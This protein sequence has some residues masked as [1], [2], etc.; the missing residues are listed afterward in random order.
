MSDT[1]SREKRKQNFVDA[2]VQGA[3]L[4]RICAHW[5]IFFTVAA[6][7]VVLIKTLLG[8]PAQSFSQRFQTEIGEF[9][10]IGLV[11]L[12]LFP[13]FMLDTIRFSNRFVGP[14]ARVRRHLRQL[15]EGDTQR[16]SF[17]END[18]WGELANDF[19]CAADLVDRQNSEL[20]KLITAKTAAS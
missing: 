11:M 10:L 17:R 7:A 16:C 20:A 9:A 2:H 19:N 1:N 15:G 12:T 5:I 18:F 4:R 6:V 3:L 14:I 8:D 13:A